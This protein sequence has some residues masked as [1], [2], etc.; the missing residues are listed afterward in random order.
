M[1]KALSRMSRHVVI[2]EDHMRQAAA[3]KGTL[4]GRIV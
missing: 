2:D 3:K 4:P 1:S